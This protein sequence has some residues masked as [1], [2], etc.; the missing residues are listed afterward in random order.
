[1]G[2]FEDLRKRIMGNKDL[3]PQDLQDESDKRFGEIPGI[4]VF[5]TWDNREAMRKAKMHVVPTAGI[6][7]SQDGAYSIV[8]SGGYVDDS[9]DGDFIS[10]TGAGGTEGRDDSFGGDRSHRIDQTFSHP[11]NRALKKSAEMGKPV[12]VIRGAALKSKY[13]PSFGYR[14]D[15]LYNVIRTYET[16][17]KEGHIVCK[18]ELKRQE[19]QPPLPTRRVL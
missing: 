7:G 4:P 13:A 6:A 8:L 9:D 10:Y 2:R 16:K 17:G 11:H 19:G 15:G 18:F 12:R 5:S 3:Y 14:Y 1:M